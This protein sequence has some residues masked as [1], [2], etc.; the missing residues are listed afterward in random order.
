MTS[1]RP[2]AVA[3]RCAALDDQESELLSWAAL[4]APQ[5]AARLPEE[6]LQ[7]RRIVATNLALALHREGLA[8]PQLRLVLTHDIGFGRGIVGELHWRGAPVVEPSPL[9][10]GHVNLAQARDYHAD[11]GNAVVHLALTLA[12]HRQSAVQNAI[13]L[14]GADLLKQCLSMNTTAANLLL[15]QA[16]V[17]GHNVHPLG[18]LRRG[19][20]PEEALAY[21]AECRP[22]GAVLLRFVAVRK[23]HMR[24]TSALGP[25][26]GRHLDELLAAEFPTLGAA[27][28][29]LSAPED[30]TL[31]PVHPWQYEHTVGRSYSAELAAGIIIP[32]AVTLP[33]TPTT[34]LRTLVSQ[35][36]NTGR[37]WTIKTALNVWFTSTRRDISP[38]TTVNAAL[39][40]QTIATIVAG[41][42]WLRSRVGI[43]GEVAGSCF[44]P[45]TTEP[46]P[47][48]ARGL[49]AVLRADLAPHA[50]P[51]QLAISC[52]S[53]TSGIREAG[54]TLLGRIVAW[55]AQ[56]ANLGID[57]AA[58]QFL[59]RYADCLVSAM[60][61]L[62]TKYGIGLEGHLQNTVLL[63]GTGS[64]PTRLLFRD[65]G[66]VRIH[67]PR[68]AAAGHPIVA[69]PESVITS[70]SITPVRDKTYYSCIQA[71]LAEIV[72]G[73]VVEFSLDADS[74]WQSIWH[75]LRQ[76]FDYVSH[77]AAGAHN[78]T[79]DR[80]ALVERVVPQKA[81]VTMALHPADG[82][83]YVNVPNPLHN[84][85]RRPQA[86]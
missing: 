38:A 79:E 51:G 65:F 53:L 77:T 10:H 40:S 39:I 58:R 71:N 69:H 30:Y 78:A 84:A 22:S 80:A 23:D 52:S 48:R 70:E 5:L 8:A 28:D 86:R 12:R 59:T 37:R 66:G 17:L 41:D 64:T 32:L 60:V 2:P 57:V 1:Q 3:S 11:V 33:T 29:G 47:T 56:S 72:L 26:R 14:G 55:L 18:R 35:P 20:H 9:L 62:L 76:V 68:I 13:D 19:I 4:R 46:D 7:A 15:D 67:L 81:F 21:A 24:R 36:G 31:V 25:L 16:N 50:G 75:Q 63:L 42:P 6:L 49:S 27:H 43:I 74:C 73:L 44:A 34:S 85:A 82:T 45:A 54:P 83:R 61:V